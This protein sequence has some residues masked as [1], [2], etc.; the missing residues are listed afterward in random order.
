MSAATAPAPTVSRKPRRPHTAGRKAALAFPIPAPGEAVCVGLGNWE[1]YLMLDEAL[2][3]RGFRVRFHRGKIEIMSISFTHE[4][5]KAALRLLIEAFCDW[6]NLDFIPW[7]STTQK[8]ETDMGGEPDES[9]TFGSTRGRKPEMVLEV[10]LSSGGIEKLPFWAEKAIPEVW[11]WQNGRLHIFG[12]H[13]GTYA[14]LSQSKC[15]SGFP[16]PLAEELLPMEPTSKAV[17]E[18]RRRLAAGK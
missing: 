16:I 6:K 13:R 10:A 8:V 2:C 11:I 3:D 14:P 15:L 12:F 9:Y 17:R 1:T 4:S 18:F 5:I 7:G